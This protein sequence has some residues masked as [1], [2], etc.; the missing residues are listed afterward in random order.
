MEEASGDTM[1]T[2]GQ[3]EE[4]LHISYVAYQPHLVITHPACLGRSLILRIP[5]YLRRKPGKTACSPGSMAWEVVELDRRLRY[6]W[7]ADAATKAEAGIDFEAEAWSGDGE[8][9]FEVTVQNTGQGPNPS[10]P[11]LFCLQAG[12]CSDFH[13]YHGERTFLRCG[14]Q[15]RTVADLIGGRWEDHRM[16]GFAVDPAADAAAPVTARLMV[17]ES[18]DGGMVL[19]IAVDTATRLSCNHQLWPSCIHANPEWGDVA[20]GESKTARGKVYWFRGSKDELLAR[21]RRDFE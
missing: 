6:R 2:E 7:A 8:V 13:D 5:E 18:A 4:Q 1:S 14:E 17:K 9:R 20:P 19:G 10:E 3:E 21:H 11:S 16:C 12:G 15:W